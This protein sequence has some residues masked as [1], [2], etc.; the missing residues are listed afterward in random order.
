MREA[1]H[2]SGGFH[3]LMAELSGNRILADQVW[4]LV[5]RTSLV[6]NLFENQTGLAGWRDH[7]DEL[8]QLCAG[9]KMKLRQTGCPFA[10]W[11]I[12]PAWFGTPSARQPSDLHTNLFAHEV[13][14]SKRSPPVRVK[15]TL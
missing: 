12:R 6:I 8:I 10:Q 9:R 5:A 2:L 11:Q 1:I 14:S 3:V 15:Q 7:H 13:Y 4:L